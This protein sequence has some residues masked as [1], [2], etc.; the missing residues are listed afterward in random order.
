MTSTDLD[1]QTP[2]V[3]DYAVPSVERLPTMSDVAPRTSRWYSPG[4]A[5]RLFLPLA[6][7]LM[8]YLLSTTGAIKELYFPSPTT[9]L[10]ALA[11][12]VST[13]ELQEALPA[14]LGRA[15]TGLTV[16][17]VIGLVFGIANGLFS[18]FEK[19]F[20]SSFQIVRQ[21]PF[22]AMIPLFIIWF[23]IGEQF[24]VIVISL[25]CVFPI[26]INT[27]HGVRH[28]DSR[29][30]EA[31]QVFG[32]SRL[33]TIVTVIL[34]AALPQILVGLR[35]S[36]GVSLLALI[37]AEQVNSKSGIGHIIFVATGALRID[38]IAAAII[39]YALFGVVVDIVMRILE[40]RLLPWK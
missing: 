3:K 29:L 11:E 34:P 30:V 37:V 39:I 2:V 22:I 19:L 23:G 4:N 16:G 14:S 36:M 7:L 26:Y 38:I 10:E 6:A 5:L 15:A 17:L 1:S 12:L 35:M 18:L 8:W 13:G 20:D 9:V 32:L 40:H 33:A 28:V 24:K 25:A 21:V 31:A 27:Y